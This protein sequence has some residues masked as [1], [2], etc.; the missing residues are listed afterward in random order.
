M[1]ENQNV[2]I[3]ILE[4]RSEEHE[5][6]LDKIDIILEK[7]RNRPPVWASLIIAGLLAVIGYFVKGAA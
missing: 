3:G 6:R 5:T 4:T 1:D 7:V 2:K